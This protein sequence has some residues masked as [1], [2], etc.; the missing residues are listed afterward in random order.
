[1]E[2]IKFYNVRQEP[3]SI[4]GL[5][6]AKNQ[7][8]FCRLPQ[9]VAFATSKNISIL[10]LDLS[11]GRVRFRTDSDTVAVKVERPV[12][13]RNVRVSPFVEFG[14]DFYMDTKFGQRF[15]ASGRPSEAEDGKYVYTTK[16]LPD[17]EKEI[18]VYLPAY[19][20]I[21]DLEIGLR[22]GATLSAHR[23]YTY[24]KPVLY[25]G[26]SI[27]QGCAAT[28]SGKIYPAIISRRFD[29]DFIDLGFAGSCMGEEVLA[30]YMAGLDMSVF[31]S[32]Y[33]H[34]RSCAESLASNH[35]RLYE[36]IRDKHPDIPY[37]MISR[38]DFRFDKK[39]FDRRAVVMESY[40]KAWRGGDP[41]VYFIDGSAFFDHPDKLEFTQDGTHPS[42]E[43]FLRMANIIGTVFENT[44][45]FDKLK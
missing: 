32:D 4:H 22:E 11:G 10:Y 1:M 2:N 34:N 13:E 12:R 7:K 42:D 36:I 44:I 40:L 3:F 45:D 9:D 14:F 5:Y 38:P 33:D 30:K 28:R 16:G 35:F 39:D 15:L 25:Y 20:G 29:W 41:N 37:Y 23:P 43:G 18:T 27:T 17:G 31:V 6:D 8:P 19:G 21:I 26:S 24:T